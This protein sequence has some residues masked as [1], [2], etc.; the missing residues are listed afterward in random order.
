MLLLSLLLRFF[1]LIHIHAEFGVMLQQE[2]DCA[3]K[4]IGCHQ[5]LPLL[6]LVQNRSI[7]YGGGTQVQ[8]LAIGANL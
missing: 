6:R 2:L 3:L 7:M 4:L 1:E 5:T 8:Q